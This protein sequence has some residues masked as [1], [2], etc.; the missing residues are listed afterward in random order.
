MQL[1]R[2]LVGWPKLFTV[3]CG[4]FAL[5]YCVL[6]SADLSAPAGAAASVPR[7]SPLFDSSAHPPTARQSASMTYDNVNQRM[8]LFGGITDRGA[9][10]NDVWVLSLTSPA[11][12]VQVSPAGP[13]PPV[14]SGHS[15]AYDATRQEMVIL[16]GQGGDGRLSDVWVL[17][18][19]GTPTWS[20]L[21]PAG[22]APAGLTQRTVVYDAAN[23]RFVV[24]G[25]D[26]NVGSL[27]VRT[28]T[29]SNSPTWSELTPT[30]T[31]PQPVPTPLFTTAPPSASSLS[32][33]QPGRFGRCRCPAL[34]SGCSSS[35]ARNQSH[36]VR[37]IRRLTIQ[38]D[39]A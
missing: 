11:A 18:L 30:G 6:F 5:I 33:D 23:R 1:L 31:P 22:P 12:W 35:A 4:G 37:S 29:L 8:V 3:W 25:V 21:F 13:Q 36:R 39:N 7:W 15:A 14:R 9:R 27:A 19:A 2:A 10:L 34:R 28:L 16:G 17:S 20:Q 26:T 38:H 32:A 24:V